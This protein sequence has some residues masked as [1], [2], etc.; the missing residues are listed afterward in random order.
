[1]VKTPAVPADRI[2]IWNFSA[3]MQKESGSGVSIES[4]EGSVPQA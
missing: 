3:F 4:R 1:M 2:F